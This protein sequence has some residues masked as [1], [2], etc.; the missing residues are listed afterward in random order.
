MFTGDNHAIWAS[1]LWL[2]ER[3]GMLWS[4]WTK[5]ECALRLF[6]LMGELVLVLLQRFM[7]LLRNLFR[8]FCRE[9]NLKGY[10]YT[11]I[12]EWFHKDPSWSKYRDSYRFHLEPVRGGS[13][14][15]PLIFQLFHLEPP[16]A[17][18]CSKSHFIF[19][20]FHLDLTQGSPLRTISPI[21]AFILPYST[22][23]I[24][25]LSFHE[26]LFFY[27]FLE[28][29]LIS[30]VDPQPFKNSFWSIIYML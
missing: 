1:A 14:W 29:F 6:F 23:E 4:N 17:T 12:Y 8:G 5:R 22:D 19:Q 13:T 28:P 27:L 16:K 24:I 11:T 10:I 3:T 18:R 30:W 15:N 21:M 2:Q 25:Q 9:V 7:V 26:S 20:G